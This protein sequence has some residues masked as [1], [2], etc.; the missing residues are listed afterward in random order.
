[1]R[2]LL[3]LAICL[4]GYSPLWAQNPEDNLREE[5]FYPFQSVYDEPYSPMVATDSALFY[6]AIQ[7]TGDLFREATDFKFSFVAY[8][9]RGEPYRP[10]RMTFHGIR[11]PSRYI[12]ALNALYINRYDEPANT[13]HLPAKTDAEFQITGETPQSVRNTTLQFSGRNYL[14]GLRLSIVEPLGRGWQ[15]AATVQGR[16]GRDLYADGVFSNSLNASVQL[17]KRFRD[18][19]FISVIAVVP[20]SMRSLRSSSTQEAFELT[21]N[22][23]Y[24]PSW[25][26]QNGEIRSGRIRRETV[27]LTAAVYQVSLSDGTSLATSFTAETGVKRYSTLAWYDAPSPLPDY[28]RWMPSYQT[29]PTA[30]LEMENIWRTND[31]RYTQINWDEFYLQNMNSRDGSS[32]YVLEDRTERIT[33]LQFLAEGITRIGERLTVRYGIRGARMHSRFYKE[34]RDLMGRGYF[35]D[36]DYYLVDD[37]VY[38][39]KLQNDL[40]HPNRIIREGDRFGYDYDLRR[41]EIGV[42]GSLEYHADRLRALIATNI[43]SS[44]LFRRGHY[45]KELF[46]GN[47]SF[48]KSRT[49]RFTPYRFRVSAGYSFS[50]RH[51]LE[52][53]LYTA[54]QTPDES[55]LFLNQEY[56]NRPV[57]NPTTEK[58]YGAEIGYTWTGRIIRFRATFYVVRTSD[59]T[60]IRHY[61]DDF[62]GTYSDMTASGIGTLR[63]GV[64]ATALIRLAYRWNL[65]LAVNAGR[66]RYADN[67]R[68]TVYADTNNEVLDHDARSYL[69]D[70]VVGNTPQV[71]GFAGLNYYGPKGWGVQVEGAWAGNRYVEPSL[72]RRTPR[73][74]RQMAESP[75]AF[76]LFTRQE[77]LANA[78][79]LNATLFKSFY[80]NASRLTLMLSVRNIL[81]DTDQFFSGYESSRIRRIRTADASVYRPLDTRYLYAYPRTFYASISFKF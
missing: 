71:T 30:R 66:Y 1:M 53:T 73:I 36:R 19:H 3:C 5:D 75:E 17:S 57:D 35:I 56:N 58:R 51:Y 28:Y 46:P 48:G 22:R 77:R 33:N 52:M 72:I 38:G 41:N 9:R 44:S 74:A 4:I 45:E 79:T 20:A 49:L 67:P 24:N 25:G 18:R 65:T 10:D 11:L 50:A 23:L 42:G 60:Q 7:S 34:M 14:M 63:Y 31:T 55:D 54:S 62:F 81:N 13:W 43:E 26:Y 76:D 64:E 78:F 27:P 32:T 70:C 47:E 69:G 15:I 16:T 39:N 40:R 80:F 6:R 61:Y 8:N 29:D 59:G 21:G 2:H 12:P 68:I 37:G